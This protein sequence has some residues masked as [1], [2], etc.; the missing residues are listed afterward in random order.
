MRSRCAP[1]PIAKPVMPDSDS[2]SRILFTAFPNDTSCQLMPPSTVTKPCGMAP[3]NP[4]SASM[5]AMPNSRTAWSS[6]SV[7]SFQLRPPSIVLATKRFE[8]P[9]SGSYDWIVQ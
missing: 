6:T 1:V 5:K 8:D 4:V 7:T 9:G 2:S 3:T